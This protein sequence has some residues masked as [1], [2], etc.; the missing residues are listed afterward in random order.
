MLEGKYNSKEVEKRWQ[1]YWEK[2]GIYK[3]DVT[4]TRDKIYSIDNPP[5]TVSGKIHIGHVFSYSQIEMMARYM[6]MRGYNVFYPFGFDDNGLPTERLVEKKIGKKAHQ[7]S[8]EE[9]NEL[10]LETTQQYE[11]Q[12]KD[13]FK[14]LGFS[15]DWDLMYST[16]SPKAQ[17]T[18]QKSFIDLYKK[19]KVYHSESPC[20]WCTECKTSIAQAELDTKETD[21]KFNY[22][23]FYIPETN[24]TLEIATT[25]P[26]LLPG[27]V[28]VFINPEDKE[29]AKYIGKE[30]IVPMLNFRVP[31]IADPKVD[32]E[33]GTGAVMCCTFGDA[34]DVEWWKK[35]N[36]SLKQ[37]IGQDGR[38]VENIEKYGGMKTEDARKQIIEDLKEQGYLLRQEDIS[39]Q[40]GV[41]ERC[42]T[43]AEFSVSKQ[44]YID[45]LSEK[46]RFLKAGDKINWNPK[47]MKARYD[48]WVKNL[49]WDWGI[50][51]QR[52]FGV[53]FPVWYCNSC[54]TPKIASEEQL[55]VNPLNTQPSK[56]C[57]CG[58]EDFTPE[59]D[60]MDTWATSSVT[61]LIN[62]DWGED[63]K[64]ELMQKLMPMSLRPNAHDIIRTWDFYTIV[65]NLY[66]TGE[67]P[68]ENIMIAGHV[69]AN[70]GEKI[71]KSKNNGAME[72]EK[73]LQ[74]YSAD[75]IRYWTAS[76]RL[77][78]DVLFSEDS[79]KEANKFINK[80]W[81]VSKFAT[82]HLED[83][84]KKKAE[85]I[86]M[87]PMD[88]YI[89][90][91]LGK[92]M[93][94]FSANLSKYEPGLALKN[95]EKF[96]WE[97]CD[98][99]VEIVKHRLYNPDIYGEDAR[100]S[101][102]KAMYETMLQLL[103]M[104]AIY[105]P[106]ITEEIYQQFFKQNEKEESIHQSR[107]D[108]FM[109]KPDEELI[110]N[111]DSVIELISSTRRYKSENSLSLRAP[112]KKATL[113]VTPE[114]FSFVQDSLMDIKNATNS[115]IIMILE[116]KDNNL[117][118]LEIDWEEVERLKEE[119][120]QKK[121]REKKDQNS[122]QNDNNSQNET[123]QQTF[124]YRVQTVPTASPILKNE[125][126]NLKSNN[127]EDRT[128][129]LEI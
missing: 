43:P 23:K 39:H 5:P 42:G 25:R 69:L 91:K 16:I 28:A 97:Y 118:D 19:N 35:Y 8:R 40:I 67:I 114:H 112:I 51:R 2:I 111:G 29:K 125:S 73:L 49:Q 38:I 75:A 7:V 124:P 6:R 87:L 76:G 70:K 117:E 61:P 98:N 56:P 48:D 54:G 68:W 15:A 10:C 90:S 17:K 46:E 65:K 41:H 110:R 13:L 100:I 64:G 122:A 95:F 53:P 9:F 115:N 121:E 83:Y 50:S 33:K 104:G 128:E 4:N 106:H 105:M 127:R 30:I 101:G 103:K 47:N 24:E 116:G 60:V 79:L 77:G 119:K 84:D 57:T 102:Q 88:R 32:M 74:S 126:C 93:E 109:Y 82:M 31:I 92:T 1:E 81:N 129:N 72:P 27:C 45:I 11:K 12:F 26:E 78:N 44:W 108:G 21:T 18:A 89:L 66:H 86:E 34:T 63:E 99:Y 20:L 52:F 94:E 85:Q 22:L 80:L 62:L 14:S 120:R 96:F 107:I 58:C 123:M 71:S 113:R 37:I 3:F 36:L 59:K 55:P